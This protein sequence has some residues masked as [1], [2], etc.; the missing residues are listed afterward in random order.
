MGQQSLYWNDHQ[1]FS[2]RRKDSKSKIQMKSAFLLALGNLVAFSNAG[3]CTDACLVAEIACQSACAADFWD[4]PECG[5]ACIAAK[6]ACDALCDRR[7]LRLEQENNST[8]D[9]GCTE[10]KNGC[11]AGCPLLFDGSCLIGC[12]MKESLCDAKCDG[13]VLDVP[14][15][16]FQVS[17]NILASGICD[18]HIVHKRDVEHAQKFCD[19]VNINSI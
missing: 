2:K 18:D 3:I 13:R 8:C 1:I 9:D 5:I 10:I 7:L 4:E 14:D 16:Q 12:L 11:E 15:F 19:F 6:P 17:K